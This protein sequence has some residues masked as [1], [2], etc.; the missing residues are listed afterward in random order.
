MKVKFLDVQ[1]IILPNNTS[2]DDNSFEITNSTW[3][4]SLT[5]SRRQWLTQESAVHSQSEKKMFFQSGWKTSCDT[6][7]T[8][9]RTDV[10]SRPSC[11][12]TQIFSPKK[13]GFSPIK[14]LS[15]IFLTFV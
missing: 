12:Y 15:K 3:D 2:R 9:K 1:N 7:A 8:D 6:T 13:T 14:I 11:I 5:R 10:W 4:I